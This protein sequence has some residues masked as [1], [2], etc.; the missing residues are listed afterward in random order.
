MQLRIAA[1]ISMRAIHLEHLR[2]N[3]FLGRSNIERNLR[4]RRPP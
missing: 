4:F 2:R 3:A 1:Q